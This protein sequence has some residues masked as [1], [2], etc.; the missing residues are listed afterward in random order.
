LQ[1]T[2]ASVIRDPYY[3]GEAG[4]ENVLDLIEEASEGLLKF[5]LQKAKA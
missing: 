2:P 5:I 3:G 1:T 4:F